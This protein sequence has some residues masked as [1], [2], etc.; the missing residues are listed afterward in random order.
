MPQ[1][2]EPKREH[3]TNSGLIFKILFYECFQTQNE[4]LQKRV[5]S[6]L[7]SSVDTGQ[8]TPGKKFLMLG[9]LLNETIFKVISKVQN[10]D[11][12]TSAQQN[13]CPVLF[14]M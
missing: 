1:V 9:V 7:K 14:K 2:I 8:T 13:K 3:D 11:F 5:S 10:T 6:S 12:R 4:V